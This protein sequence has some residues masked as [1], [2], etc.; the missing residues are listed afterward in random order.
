[1]LA[2]VGYGFG[3]PLVATFEAVGE[4]RDAK[5]FHSLTV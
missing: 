4:S 1:L 5:L 2:G 3:Q